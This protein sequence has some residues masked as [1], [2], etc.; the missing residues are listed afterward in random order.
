MYLSM[1]RM[2]CSIVCCPGLYAFRIVIMTIFLVCGTVPHLFLFRILHL[3]VSASEHTA[4]LSSARDSERSS[5]M[6]G[7]LNQVCSL[8]RSTCSTSSIYSANVRVRSS[9]PLWRLCFITGYV[10]CHAALRGRLSGERSVCE[11]LWVQAPPAFVC[12]FLFR[13]FEVTR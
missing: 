12:F 13:D 1:R 8:Y 3:Q 9:L 5:G 11:R 6:R 4:P 2:Y 10:L 7:S